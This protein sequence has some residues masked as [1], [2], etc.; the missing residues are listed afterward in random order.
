M[1]HDDLIREVEEEIESKNNLIKSKEKIILD[2]NSKIIELEN[3]KASEIANIQ[4]I[5]SKDKKS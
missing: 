4:R 3:E 2:L 1:M 5:H